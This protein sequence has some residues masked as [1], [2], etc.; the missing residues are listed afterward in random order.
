MLLEIVLKNRSGETGSNVLL[1]SELFYVCFFYLIVFLLTIEK[2][3]TAT[4]P[5]SNTVTDDL[6]VHTLIMR[7]N[8][9]NQLRNDGSEFRLFYM[10]AT[11]SPSAAH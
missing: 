9:V 10:V 1:L 8:H 7:R 6:E 4:G 5:V 11:N 3:I 2:P